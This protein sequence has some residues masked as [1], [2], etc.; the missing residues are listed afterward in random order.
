MQPEH[1]KTL[2]KQCMAILTRFEQSMAQG[3]SII[4][5]SIT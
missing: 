5:N 1:I 2:G 4:P 3:G